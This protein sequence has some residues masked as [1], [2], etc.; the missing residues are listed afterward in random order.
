MNLE[1]DSPVKFG[2]MKQN[3]M[4]RR[5]KYIVTFERFESVF[6]DCS[7]A[8][9]TKVTGNRMN[10]CHKATDTENEN[11]SETYGELTNLSDNKT[12][13]EIFLRPTPLVRG[14]M[15]ELAQNVLTLKIHLRSKLLEIAVTKIEPT[16]SDILEQT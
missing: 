8:V 16:P 7:G 1:S 5:T 3:S 6:T 9:K 4:T 15:A 10:F 14:T 11:S 13:I 12:K 2:E